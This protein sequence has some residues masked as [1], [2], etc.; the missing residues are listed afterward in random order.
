MW[1]PS[2][3]N[4]PLQNLPAFVY[5]SEPQLLIFCLELVI[6]ISG[7]VGR[8]VVYSVLLEEEPSSSIL[9]AISNI[10]TFNAVILLFASLFSTCYMFCIFL[11]LVSISLNILFHLPILLAC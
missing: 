6:F 1:T 10:F 11:L 5:F 4:I 8:L 7:C 3:S 9:N 2:P